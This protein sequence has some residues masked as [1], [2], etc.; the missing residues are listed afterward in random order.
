MPLDR[1]G[2]LQ[3]N[4]ILLYALYVLNLFFK[5]CDMVTWVVRAEEHIVMFVLKIILSIQKSRLYFYKRLFCIIYWI[6]TCC[7]FANLS[8]IV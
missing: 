7:D 5:F 3:G 1:D 2:I 8:K 6:D 4:G